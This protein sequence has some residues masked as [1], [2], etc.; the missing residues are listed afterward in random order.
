MTTVECPECKLLLEVE[1]SLSGGDFACPGCN[2]VLRVPTPSMSAPDQGGASAEAEEAGEAP[3]ADAEA[4]APSSNEE[5]QEPESAGAP[6]ADSEAMTQSS[7]AEEPP[8]ST[9][10]P[11]AAEAMAQSTNEEEPAESAGAPEAD[12]EAMTQ[13]SKA[14][15]PPESTNAPEADSEAVAQSPKEEEPSE[16]AGAPEAEAEAVAQSTKAEEPPESAGS[17]E[18][19]SEGGTGAELQ[20]SP[21]E[22]SVAATAVV[23]ESAPEGS[24][25]S[26]PSAWPDQLDLADPSDVK[27][28]NSSDD[29]PSPPAPVEGWPEELGLADE[30]PEQIRFDCEACKESMAVPP[31][32]AGKLGRCKA[33]KA[34]IRVPLRGR[35]ETIAPDEATESIEFACPSC[36]SSMTVP[37]AMAGRAGRCKSC[38]A[39]LTVPSAGVA[40]AAAIAARA[41]ITFDCPLCKAAMTVP[42][43]FAGLEG[44]CKSCDGAIRVP[45]PEDVYTAPKTRVDTVPNRRA[46]ES[47][48]F[49]RED[50]SIVGLLKVSLQSFWTHRYD[51]LSIAAVHVILVTLVAGAF[52]AVG[53]FLLEPILNAADGDQTA[54]LPAFLLGL[55]SIAQR[56]VLLGLWLGLVFVCLGIHRRGECEPG[57][58]LE[59]IIAIPRAL[60][61]VATFQIIFVLAAMTLSPLLVSLPIVGAAF[62]PKSPGPGLLGFIVLGVAVFVVAVAVLRFTLLAPIE[63]LDRSRPGPI[64]AVVESFNLLDGSFLKA[65]AL[66]ACGMI[67]T[68]PVQAAGFV[69]QG[70]IPLPLDE[71]S[72]QVWAT[73]EVLGE[74][75]TQPFLALLLSGLYLTLKSR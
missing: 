6:E 25:A 22:T 27:V 24:D 10:A 49:S 23:T 55:V 2:T 7:K 1:E 68:L 40:R 58:Y 31:E 45:R 12:S 19:D 62:D 3:E 64:V 69:S 18:R 75:L 9:N 39:S 41:G 43:H 33:C 35:V 13:S 48:D 60:L 73:L 59:G 30:A 34:Q 26:S 8:E 4:M 11:E 38:R 66:L 21:R 14:E 52:G 67:I 57:N 54:L 42:A 50:W 36:R 28:P 15:E 46:R 37:A 47:F 53:G 71:H 20:A 74:G 29:A 56:G 51:L 70:L 5:E 65:L 16:S 32:F 17:P 72:L 63:L 61:L 44:R